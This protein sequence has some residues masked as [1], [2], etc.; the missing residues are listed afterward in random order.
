MSEEDTPSLPPPHG[1]LDVPY[2]EWWLHNNPFQKYTNGLCSCR[3]CGSD[4]YHFSGCPYY[5]IQQKL[6]EIK[7]LMEDWRNEVRR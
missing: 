2:W 3:I 6:A 7:R 5:R 4:T 1:T